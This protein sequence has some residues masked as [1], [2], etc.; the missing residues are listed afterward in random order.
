MDDFVCTDIQMNGQILGGNKFSTL[1]QFQMQ[2]TVE[3]QIM[4]NAAM[5]SLFTWFYRTA[6]PNF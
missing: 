4:F 2:V 6:L 5:L 3:S 1:T